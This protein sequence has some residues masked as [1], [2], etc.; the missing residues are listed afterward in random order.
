MKI[1]RRRGALLVIAAGV[2]VALATAGYV[3]STNRTPAGRYR[4]AAVD[5]GTIVA[6]VS[7]TGQLNAVTTVLVGMGGTI[8]INLGQPPKP[9]AGTGTI[10]GRVTRG[11]GFPVARANV[12]ALTVPTPGGA[13]ISV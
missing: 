6:T 7:A 4:T 8:R 1:M 9:P 13:R 10:R 5:R 12:T 2:L 11:D 3:Y